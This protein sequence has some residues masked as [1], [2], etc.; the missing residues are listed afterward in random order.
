LRQRRLGTLGTIDNSA[1]S[2]SDGEEDEPEE[3]SKEKE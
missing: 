1:P 3:K 2:E